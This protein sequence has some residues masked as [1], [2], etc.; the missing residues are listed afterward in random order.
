MSLSAD[1]SLSCDEEFSSLSSVEP[2]KHTVRT[3]NEDSFITQ[4]QNANDV[5]PPSV[6]WT[7]EP[8]ESSS[9][10]EDESSGKQNHII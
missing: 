7:D 5:Y 4:G 3:A 9:P 6:C 8:D 10:D 2:N 1:S